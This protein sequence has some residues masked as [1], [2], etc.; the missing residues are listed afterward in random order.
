MYV[1]FEGE[2]PQ[3]VAFA[4]ASMRLTNYR[5]PG[6]EREMPMRK[7]FSIKRKTKEAFKLLTPQIIKQEFQNYDAKVHS[8]NNKS[9]EKVTPCFVITK[10][11]LDV[12]LNTIEEELYDDRFQPEKIFRVKSCVTNKE[13]RLIRVLTKD[14]KQAK[15]QS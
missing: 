1:D 12:S 4:Y 13:T 10:V 9:Q 5:D 7:G 3:L 11:S 2:R 15:K 14:E 6:C 8:N